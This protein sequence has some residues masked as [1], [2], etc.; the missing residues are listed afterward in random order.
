VSASDQT[1]SGGRNAARRTEGAGY[2]TTGLMMYQY[3]SSP[4][5]LEDCGK[6]GVY[7]RSSDHADS[8]IVYRSRLRVV[9]EQ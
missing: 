6:P 1:A 7:D 9:G 5:P 8:G 2:C 4:A 3:L